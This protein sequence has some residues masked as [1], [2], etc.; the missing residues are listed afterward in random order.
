MIT[1]MTTADLLR[2]GAARL[3]SSGSPRLDAETL[4][5]S[6]LETDR[7]KLYTRNN[8]T[9]DQGRR[10]AFDELIGRRALGY[11]MAYLLGR[12][13]FWSLDFEVDERVLIP[14]PE[15]ELVV[16]T[17]LGQITEDAAL[18]V[19]DIGTGS[20]II[21]V[22]LARERPLCRLTATDI[23]GAGL[24]I[25]RRNIKRHGCRNVT[26][27]RSNWFAGLAPKSFDMIVS[28]PPY[29]ATE[30]PVLRDSE[31]RFEPEGA[32]A[33]GPDG[34]AALRV[35]VAR[36]PRLM[37][38]DGHLILEHGCDQGAAVRAFMRRA[39]LC[40]VVTA[41]DLAGHER[42]SSARLRRPDR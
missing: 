31:I 16:E 19:A 6:V 5:S 2:D 12:T 9:V 39:G 21:A 13:E 26:T 28:N 32:L 15:T 22:A 23:C 25:A 37:R 20:G 35:I 11:P 38:D 36:A 1:A 24:T 17:A 30:D 8:E 18:D 40:D 29:V 3:S 27:R 33:A 41:R 4:L 34:L 14:R 10:T 7:A 42:V